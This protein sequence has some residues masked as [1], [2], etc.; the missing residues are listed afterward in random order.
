MVIVVVVSCS[1]VVVVVVVDKATWSITFLEG[2]VGGDGAVVGGDTG[3]LLATDAT[4]DLV[5]PVTLEALIAG[6]LELLTST[7][8]SSSSPKG[9]LHGGGI[10]S[11]GPLLLGVVEDEGSSEGE[12]PP[13]L[14]TN[15]LG[16][17]T[18]MEDNGLILGARAPVEVCVEG[19]GGLALGA[20]AETLSVDHILPTS[21]MKS[22][23]GLITDGF[24]L[25]ETS[26]GVVAEHLH[27][28]GGD[29]E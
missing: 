11:T 3:L 25:D 26:T 19:L 14:I 9:G 29:S 4:E 15:A 7:G 17:L 20:I 10:I 16:E 12:G 22:L 1:I 6:L 28:C 18:T 27:D 8:L 13:A 24:E 21:L 5:V 23:M 2:G